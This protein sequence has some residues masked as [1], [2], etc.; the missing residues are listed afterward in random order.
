[1]LLN[2]RPCA[3]HE[4][5]DST[6]CKSALRLLSKAGRRLAFRGRRLPK[7]ERTMRQT[8]EELARPRVR[9][10][11]SISPKAGKSVR[12][13]T[14]RSAEEPQKSAF[15]GSR[16]GPFGGEDYLLQIYDFRNVLLPHCD[17]DVPRSIRTRAGVDTS[18]RWTSLGPMNFV[19]SPEREQANSLSLPGPSRHQSGHRSPCGKP[20]PPRHKSSPPRRISRFDAR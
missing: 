13:S 3:R 2:G 14:I 7:H 20:V 4:A 10:K 8:L 1:V 17:G 9:K 11:P 19:E 12:K 5:L 6:K 15:R 16:K 18:A